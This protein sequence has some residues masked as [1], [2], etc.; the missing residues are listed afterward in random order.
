MSVD[1]V[2]N[3]SGVDNI[4]NATAV[5]YCMPTANYKTL[6]ATYETSLSYSDLENKYTNRFDDV[7][8]YSIGG[9]TIVGG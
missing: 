8:Y 7:T 9:A 6:N 5:V 2:T 1:V 4:K 3:V